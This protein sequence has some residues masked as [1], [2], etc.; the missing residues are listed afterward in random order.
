LIGGGAT[1]SVANG[2]AGNGTGTDTFQTVNYSS[3]LA[4]GT[5]TLTGLFGANATTGANLVVSGSVPVTMA[6]TTTARSIDGSAMTG[7]LTADTTNAV[8]VTGGS[9]A[10]VLVADTANTT[11]TGNDGAD[12]LDVTGALAGV[13]VNAGG[14]NDDI[15]L[16]ANIQTGAIINAGSG[17]DDL[18][19]AGAATTIDVDMGAGNDTV[20]LIAAVTGDV[21]GGDGTDT[22]D[23]AGAS[24]ATFSNIETVTAATVTGA[25]A[26]SFNGGGF[27]LTGNSVAFAALNANDLNISGINVD[28]AGTFTATAGLSGVVYGSNVPMTFTGSPTWANTVTGTVNADQLIGGAAVDTFTGGNGADIL[29][30]NGGADILTGGGGADTITGGEGADVINAGLAADSIVLTETTAAVD[31]VEIEGGLTFD[32]ITG[33]TT[34][35]GGDELLFDLSDLETAG[36]IV[37]GLTFDYVDLDDGVTAQAAGAVVIREVADQ[38]GGAAQA[39]VGGTDF[40][41]LIGET[42]ADLAAVETGIETGDHELTI[43]TAVAISDSFFIAWSD[44]TDTHISN[45]SFAANPGT[46]IAA[47]DLTATDMAIISGTGTLV[48]GELHTDNFSIT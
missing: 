12:N 9:A 13:T 19:F 32:T 16:D 8:T 31:T 48:T 5:N 35:T 18:D 39:A 10:D 11:I 1:T 3:N 38:A 28:A 14:G 43:S 17:N 24:A 23:L 37:A 45:V 29:T 47:A 46:D 25:D 41:V 26:A 42:Y 4:T 36:A 44:G 40:Y 6:A 21:D 22:L 34:G 7:V 20:T 27:V 2:A 15:D 30:G 33:F